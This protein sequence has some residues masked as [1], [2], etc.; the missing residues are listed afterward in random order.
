MSK[1]VSTVQRRRHTNSRLGCSVCKA[2][3]IRCDE[4]LPQCKNCLK[5]KKGVCSYLLLTQ[6]E[7]DKIKLTHSL[8][9][10]QNKLLQSNFRLPASSVTAKFATTVASTVATATTTTGATGT[11]TFTTHNLK[12]GLNG[13]GLGQQV[14]NYELSSSSTNSNTCASVLEFKFELANL[15]IQLPKFNYPPLQY[16]NLSMQD[17][18]GEFKVMNDDILSDADLEEHNK[19]MLKEGFEYKISFKCFKPQSFKKS[20]LRKKMLPKM[21]TD[22]SH[23]IV[24][25]ENNLLIYMNDMIIKRFFDETLTTCFQCLG[26]AIILNHCRTLKGSNNNNNNNNDN[27]N[28]NSSSSSNCNSAKSDYDSKQALARKL[29]KRIFE[30]FNECQSS[31]ES[32]LRSIQNTYTG[33]S[34]EIVGEEI[35]L[36]AHSSHLLTFTALIMKKALSTYFNAQKGVIM[37]FEIYSQLVERSLLR[38]RPIIDFVQSNLQHNII[39]IHLP[40]Y[41]P[42]FL[43]EIE[44]NLRSLEYIFSAS[45]SITNNP[46]IDAQFI[47]L[48][49]QYDKLMSFLREKVL[50]IVFTARN[51]SFITTYPVQTIFEI[52]KEW[53]TTCPPEAIAYK[54][55]I[56]TQYYDES[57]FYHDLATTLYTYCFAIS[58]G[59][60]AV[61]P[62]C[63]YLF[64]LTFIIPIN[65]MLN[66][67]ESLTV[68]KYNRFSQS[69]FNQRIDGMLQRHICYASRVFAFFKRRFIFYNNH[70]LWSNYYDNSTLHENRFKSRALTSVKEVPIYSFN[71]TLIRPEHYPTRDKL[72]DQVMSYIN[73][74]REDDSMVR[75]LYA[76]NIETLNI[77]NDSTLLQFDYETMLLLKDYRPL[78]D[79][80]EFTRE[81][82]KY[83]DI[84]DY[85]KD[86]ITLLSSVE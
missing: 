25:A 4:T 22:F 18:T 43:F 45:N 60:G 33:T 16:N 34:L 5:S 39:S 53:H 44:S 84:R 24:H 23:Y 6:T 76:R 85:Y 70:L 52:L 75:N 83:K 9:N 66:N 80:V 74:R 12:L 72:A 50:P 32:K 1:S 77:F 46:E 64:S 68:S 56:K 63:K 51:E 55:K 30:Q 73:Y 7:I 35:E 8:R 65:D 62:S 29:E 59:L 48:H 47:R 15:P 69:F 17:F 67:Q 28:S 42:Q 36:M 11:A 13:L 49:N 19:G 37:S 57:V 79:C 10:S 2:K 71:T 31:V 86:K 54:K 61:F 41:N 38:Q 21:V 26:E 82:L 14:T 20:S 40:S 27:Y 81:L 58:A 3:K 78:D